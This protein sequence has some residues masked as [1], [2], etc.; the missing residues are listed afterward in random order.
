MKQN[1]K[2]TVAIVLLGT[3]FAFAQEAAPATQATPAPA[4]VAAPAA[5][6]VQ[7]A[8]SPTQEVASPAP[9]P[10]EEQPAE[11]AAPAPVQ[12]AASPTQEV[13]APAAEPAAQE[14]PAPAPA[15]AP[16]PTEPATAGMAPAPETAEPAATETAPAEQTVAEPVPA[17]EPAPDAAPVAEA[18]AEQAV[19]PAPVEAA[20]VASPAPVVEAAPAPEPQNAQLTGTELQ[21]ELRG[22]LKADKS[23]YLVNGTVSVAANTVLVI[24]PGT[25]ILFTKGSSL[26]VN[27]GQ[28]V[29]AGTA[30]SPVV[31]RSAMS[32]PAAG[33]WAGIVITGENNSEIRNAQILNATNG[34]VV[35]N[36]NLKIQNSLVEGSAGYGIY[37]RNATVNANDCQFKNNQVALNLSNYAQG[38]IE[39][40]TFENNSVA[41]LNSKVSMSVVSSS[42]FK[43]NGTAVVNMGNTLIELNNTA[44]EQNAVGIS[45]SEI[46]APE[47]METAK[48]NKSNFSNKAAETVATLPPEP[49]VP[50]VDRKNLNPADEASVV[51]ESEAPAD[52]TQ[53]SWT[54]LGNV[55]L[56]GNYHYVRTRTHHGSTPEISGTDTVFSGDRYKN[57]F[58]VPGFGANASTYVLM[59]SPEG[60]TI[61]FTMD[62]TSD[63]WN[64][65]SPNP[66]T[67]RYNDSYNNVNL[68][69]F[70]LMGGDIYMS[71]MPLFGAEYT[72][73]LLKNNAD[74]PLVQLEGFFGEAKRSLVPHNRH[75]Y[76]YNDYID[77]GEAQ[78]QR[79][80]FGGFLKWAPVRRFDA[81]VGAIYANDEIEDPLLRD[82]AKASTLTTDPLQESFTMYA[83]G[84]WLFFPGDI[85][86]NGQ[87]AVGHADTTDAVRQRAINKVFSNAGLNTSSYSL[88]RKLMQNES[89]IDWLTN[90]ELEE[91]FGD[92]TGMTKSEMI[93]T[94][95]Y[96]IDKAKR[97]QKETESDRDDDRVLGQH[98]GSQNFALGASLNWN[99]NRTRIEG[100]VKYIGEN[101]YSA[102]SPDQLSNTREF[103][104]SL[105]QDIKKFWT[106]GLDYQIYVENAA[107]G[108]EKNLAG[109]AEGTHFGLVSDE[110]SDWFEK[111]ELDNDRTKY[112]HNFGL[113]NT[114]TISPR[115]QIT[116]GYALEYRSQYRPVQLRGDYMLDDGIYRDKFFTKGDGSKIAVVNGD[117]VMV[118]SAR[119]SDY[120][121][122]ADEPYLASKF[123]ERLYK[124]SFMA[125]I[126]FRAAQSV[127][128]IN[129]RWT[130]RTDDSKF[131][132]DSL[133]DEL[134]LDLEDTTWAKLGYYYHGG[135][136]FEQSYPLSI[137]TTLKNM[138]NHFQVTYRQ[139]SYVRDEMTE[140]EIT[141]EDEYEIP[142]A[143][144]FIILSLNG[145][146][147]YMLT[148]WTEYDEDFDEEET[149]VLGKINL[150]VNH[151]KHFYSDWY[152]GSAIYYRPDYLSNEYKDIYGGINL[153]YVF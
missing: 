23:P 2:G 46:L 29:V 109:L 11:Q 92:N 88:L 34:I 93:T 82:G 113:D 146:F 70:Q 81:K 13:A 150:R 76:L 118:D 94:L 56:G 98:W 141:V 121:S 66:V 39:R 10:A 71:G 112:T 89:Q 138:Q 69:D 96:L 4:P 61:E 125:G 120:M 105:E 9:T 99:I 49:E 129:G 27:Q 108:R 87:I 51:F 142:F 65:F 30:T 133:V 115:V 128:K 44:I 3:F 73:S 19:A 75:P 15:A 26:A 110:D 63:S 22:F 116:A 135:D 50:G 40:S 41:L 60:K 67:L 104:A 32:T 97:A 38:E 24:E 122:L 25:T 47:L 117:T 85:E 79:L 136:Y 152:V 106:L 132:K 144:R 72:L 84:N 48:N 80:A 36:G 20:P 95:H 137:T 100:H 33:D 74:Q 114:F 58:Q 6:P 59:I 90:D 43:N 124:Q 119:W 18:P 52:S 153:N 45:S 139:K 111:H 149:D 17:A 54:V 53:K 102:G 123:E 131:H 151:N 145:Q 107:H 83:E 5:A 140:D 55:M 68:G 62:A 64:H 77:D 127:F 101:F 134:D 86:L 78:A 148:E 31:F 8:A 12:E 14:V 91:I 35:E 126:S 28:L 143:N 7:E 21:G 42:E 37:A 147:R 103:G 57:Y 16:A 130:L 1:F